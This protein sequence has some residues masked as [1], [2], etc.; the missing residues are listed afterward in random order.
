ME[1][2]PIQAAVIAAAA[3]KEIKA[4]TKNIRSRADEA[5]MELYKNT[6]AKSFD[7][8]LETEERRVSIGTASV[9]A[10][11]GSWE[12]IDGD[13]FAE[14]AADAGATE[15]CIIVPAGVADGVHAALETAGL[16]GETRW[17][18]QPKTG[19]QTHIIDTPEGPVWDS[20]GEPVAGVEWVP[21]ATYTTIRPKSYDLIRRTASV[22]L[23][24]DPYALL[25]G[26]E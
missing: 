25:E 23:G 8:A 19:W 3:E 14:P 6:G 11:E 12:I 7:V 15:V 9:A 17:V 1:L 18:E 2:N 4:K 20:T 16:I 5:I 21:G 13:A 10:R 22:L 26:V 24:A